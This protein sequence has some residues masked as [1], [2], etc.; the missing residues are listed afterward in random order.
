MINL[1]EPTKHYAKWVKPDTK[2]HMLYDFIHIDITLRKNFDYLVPGTRNRGNV[3]KP[4]N[5][6]RALLC[7]DENVS[8]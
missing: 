7:S 1:D 6:Y 4:L 2:S 5:D 3:E 8:Y